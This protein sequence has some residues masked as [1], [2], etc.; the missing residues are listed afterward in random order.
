MKTGK[1]YTLEYYELV[2]CNIVSYTELTSYKNLLKCQLKNGIAE[3]LR[4]YRNLVC[5]SATCRNEKC[6]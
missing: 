2:E 4:T 1:I 6:T 5:K 3:I